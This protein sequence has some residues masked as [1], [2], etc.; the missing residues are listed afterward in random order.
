MMLRFGIT[1]LILEGLLLTLNITG[2]IGVD[3]DILKFISRMFDDFPQE[4][5]FFCCVIF[6]IPTCLYLP[7]F[8][9]TRN[10]E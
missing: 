4:V 5:V 3:E 9:L 6:S 1:W 8:L 2:L 7:F 10:C